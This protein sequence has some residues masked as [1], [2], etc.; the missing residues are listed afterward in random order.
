M[1]TLQEPANQHRA[2]NS[3]NEENQKH[4]ARK[5]EQ[6]HERHFRFPQFDKRVI[7]HLEKVG[8]H[9]LSVRIHIATVLAPVAASEM[10]NWRQ[11]EHAP[12]A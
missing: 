3:L 7:Q 12:G 2:Q 1:S 4:E 11:R 5:L 9:R 6:A 10:M 8:G